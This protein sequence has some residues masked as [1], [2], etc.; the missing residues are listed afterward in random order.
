MDGFNKT[1]EYLAMPLKKIFKAFAGRLPIMEIRLRTDR[2]LEVKTL[3]GNYYLGAD[4]QVSDVHRAYIVT[5]KDIK[6]TLEYVSSFSLYAYEDEIRNGYITMKGGNRIGLCGKA[7][8]EKGIVKN[9][10]NISSMNIRL[11]HEFKGCADSVVDY[12]YD[13]RKIYNTLIISPPGCGKTTILRDV[14]RQLSDG[15]EYRQGINVGVVDERSEIAACNFGVPQNDVGIRTDVLD[16][17]P[18]SEGMMMLIRSM[19]PKV[20]AVDEIGSPEDARS[21]LYAINSGCGIL[22]TIHGSSVEDYLNKISLNELVINNVF[23]RIIYL[24]DS[25]GPGT[26]EGIYNSMGEQIACF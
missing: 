15:D 8:I 14:I 12:V 26:I 4:G 20:V 25:K 17:C 3:N 21:I 18:K 10:R 23:E 11:S 2:P 5:M 7:V 22:A 9:I 16:G 13:G 1:Y 6:D 19:S 24:S